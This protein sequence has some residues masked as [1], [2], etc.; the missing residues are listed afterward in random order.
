MPA[1]HS[2]THCAFYPLW[3]NVLALP[4]VAHNAVEGIS[5][6]GEDVLVLGCGPVGLFAIAV[7]KALGKWKYTRQVKHE[8]MERIEGQIRKERVC[9]IYIHDSP[10]FL[11]RETSLH[12]S[13]L[14]TTTAWML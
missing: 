8:N 10:T 7:A 1:S 5:V 4:G 13:N 12:C 9:I 14:S 6:A 11:K 2:V 3:Y